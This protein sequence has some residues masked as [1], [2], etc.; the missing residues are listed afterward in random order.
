MRH[1]L[2]NLGVPDYTD[3]RTPWPGIKPPVWATPKKK[4][5]VVNPNTFGPR[6]P[7]MVGVG[8]PPRTVIHNRRGIGG[9]Y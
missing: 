9:R 2:G 1:I 3:P 6:Q 4:V 7:N 5:V 8:L